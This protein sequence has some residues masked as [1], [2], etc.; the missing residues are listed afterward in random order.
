MIYAQF[1][2]MS[3]GYSKPPEPI[4]LLGS[5]GIYHLDGRFSLDNHISGTKLKAMQINDRLRKGIV[6]FKIMK[7]PRYSEAKAISE[8][9][10]L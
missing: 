7:G 2:S 4:E 5:D 1:Y 6:G 10:K 9:I 8:Y 3:T